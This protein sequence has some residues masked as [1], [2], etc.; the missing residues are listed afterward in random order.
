MGGRNKLLM[1][2]EGRP[3]VARVVAAVRAS[4]A[5]PVIVVTGH[6]ADRVRAALEDTAVSFAP[7]PD[8]RAG[9]STSLRAGIAAVPA[10]ADGAIICLADMPDVTSAHIDR[11]I[12]AFDPAESRAICVPTHKGRR[13]NPVLWARKFFSEMQALTG[14]TGARALLKTHA[15]F[16]AEVAMG[17][18]GVLFDVDGAQ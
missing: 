2:V 5:R 16:V 18:A 17:D 15:E 10:D 4:R 14:D 1:D 3:M 7:N 8:Y 13:G 9:M 12:Q 11:L 6:E